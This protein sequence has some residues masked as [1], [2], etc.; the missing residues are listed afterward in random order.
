MPQTP[1]PKAVI[2]CRVSSAK[3]TINGTGLSSQETRC[4][5]YASYKG[6]QV[7]EVFQDD[8][9]GKIAKRPAMVAMLNY[10]RQSKAQSC[11]V[12]IDDISRL[13]R[14][15]EAHLEL[16]V[17]ISKAGGKLES[18][19]IEFG[20]DSDSLLIE[21]M[22]A[23]VAQHHREKNGEQT[24][25]RMRARMMN[26]Y[27]VFPAPL[28]Y[29]FERQPGNGRVLVRSEPLA[30]IIAEGLE[31][32]ATGRFQS[33]SELKRFYENQPHFPKSKK[34]EVTFRTL[35]K[36][37]SRPI[38]AGVI[39]RK[40][41][42]LN[43]I[44]G[45]HEPLISYETYLAIQS[46]SKALANAPARKDLNQDFPLRGFVTCGHCNQPMSAYW[47]KGRNKKYP[48][49]ECFQKG[50]EGHRKS[51]RK[52]VI[53]GEFE[54]LL[55]DLT[56]SEDLFRMAFHMF[57]DMWEN[58]AEKLKKLHV[59]INRELVELDKKIEQFLERIVETNNNSLITAYENKIEDLQ[60]RKHLLIEKRGTSTQN[61]G[62]IKR[63]F[64][65]AF[66]FLQNPQKLWLSD[67]LEDKRAV[68]KL[69]FVERVPYTRNEGF[70]TAKTTLPFKVLAE[71][72]G[73]GM[74]MA[75]KKGFEPS[76]RDKPPTPLAGE[77]LRPLGHLSA[78]RLTS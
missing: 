48:Y 34:G 75:E 70:R 72:S 58:K 44:E 5:E 61:S 24:K 17:L 41:W 49:Y 65:T 40:S 73:N 11:V 50:C 78:D 46:H 42:G 43:M 56:P 60:S 20:E 4:R 29:H 6:Y 67:H 18:P 37:L 3:Q 10:L 15:L 55:T 2:Y 7:T 12:I 45:K 76:R 54:S 9:T 51:I 8:M 22:L 30:S 33:R 38:Y 39:T 52:D 63:V 31:G 62:D 57:K 35:E 66:E 16:R 13:A 47:A 74:Q 27:W 53:E 32:Y 28:G 77:R 1:K 21:N 14:G 69:V 19:S 25:N 59:G 23:S 64:R 71:H 68:L 26:G 36:L